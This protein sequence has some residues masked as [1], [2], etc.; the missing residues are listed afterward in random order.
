[1]TGTFKS[2]KSLIWELFWKAVS[3]FI[4]VSLHHNNKNGF[5][6]VHAKIRSM[7]IHNSLPCIVNVNQHPLETGKKVCKLFLGDE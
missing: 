5:A 7:K 2:P 4:N 3:H 1:M 6:V